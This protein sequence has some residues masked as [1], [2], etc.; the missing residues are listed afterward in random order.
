MGVSSYDKTFP[1]GD[2]EWLD[3]F[4]DR[5]T[6]MVERQESSMCHNVVFG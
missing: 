6:R 1:V 5:L 2:P 3:A 4:M